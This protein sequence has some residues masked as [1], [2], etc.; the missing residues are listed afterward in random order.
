METE[1]DN[2]DTVLELGSILDLEG[3]EEFSGLDNDALDFSQLEDF[4]AN[5]TDANGSYFA[6]TLANSEASKHATA[7]PTSQASRDRILVITTTNDPAIYVGG[8]PAPPSANSRPTAYPAGSLPHNLPDSPP[9]SGSE[10]PYSPTDPGSRSP[11]HKGNVNGRRNLHDLLVHPIYTTPQQHGGTTAATILPL[12]QHDLQALESPLPHIAPIHVPPLIPISPT[13]AGTS[14]DSPAGNPTLTTLEGSHS[15]V[16]G[17]SSSPGGPSQSVAVQ[18]EALVSYYTQLTPIHSTPSASTETASVTA[19]ASS[20]RGGRKRKS[21][22][23]GAASNGKMV[24]VKQEPGFSAEMS[25]SDSNCSN[26]NSSNG[27]CGNGANMDD[28]Y[29]FDFSGDPSMFLDSNYQCIK[30]QAFQENTWHTLT[31]EAFKELTMPYYKVDADKGFNFSNSDDAF[32]CQK[33]NHFQIT[34]HARVQGEPKYVKA[35]DGYKP[36]ENF[37]VHFYGVKVESPN[38]VIKIEQSQSDRSKKPFHPVLMELTGEQ[39]SKITVG[40]LHFNETT[41]NNMRKKGKPNPDQR[42]F[43]LVVSFNAHST[44][45]GIYPIVAHSSQRIIVRVSCRLASNP[46][47]F[48]SDME[49][50]WQKGHTSD[51]IYHAGRVGINTD[52]PEEALVVYGNC[53]VTGQITHPSDSRAKRDIT[54]LDTKEQLRNVQQL[55]VVR[56]KYNP[57]FAKMLGLAEDEALDTGVIAQE[58]RE[59]IP[60][61]VKETGNVELANGQ[62]IDNFLVV[63]KERIFMENIGAVKELCKVTGKLE[64]RIDQLEKITQFQRGDAHSSSNND[65]LRKRSVRSDSRMRGVSELLCSNRCVQ[66]LIV[67]LV[68]IMAFCLV[69]MATLYILEYHKRSSF[70]YYHN[71]RH[72]FNNS[73]AYVNHPGS[74]YLNDVF[75]NESLRPDHASLNHYHASSSHPYTQSTKPSKVPAKMTTPS[76]VKNALYSQP[77]PVV[78]PP[79]LGRPEHC[80]A[81]VAY[82]NSPCKPYCCPGTNLEEVPQDYFEIERRNHVSL[83]GAFTSQQRSPINSATKSN[84]SSNSTVDTVSASPTNNA[85]SK[86]GLEFKK[87][88]RRQI[89]RDTTKLITVPSIRIV[90]ESINQSLDFSYCMVNSKGY[91]DCVSTEN[92]YFSGVNLTYHVPLSKYWDELNLSVVFNFSSKFEISKPQVCNEFYSQPDCRMSNVVA[93]NESDHTSPKS[94]MDTYV[95]ETAG[96]NVFSITLH[97]GTSPYSRFNVRFSPNLEDYENICLLNDTISKFFE[98]N[99]H[100]YRVCDE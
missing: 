11:N 54:E 28:D 73:H 82:S 29:G 69:A 79:V 26:N 64:T 67:V 87:R 23:S 80:P 31:D 70:E 38:Q 43:Y 91:H 90:S 39:V 3:R 56:Y 60:E 93:N 53:K 33:K 58:V 83:T 40:R 19:A 18:G 66:M 22:G 5:E 9:D 55:R 13:A 4:I 27:N 89:N 77:Q 76:I 72:L 46:G 59:I 57:E 37:Y 86:N 45:G 24:H 78:K 20:S 36:I 12:I 92:R 47:Q 63:N 71:T 84:T 52:R 99:F 7:Q 88:R 61:A 30:F 85:V 62:K 14:V 75:P 100:F 49:L 68:L 98:F 16:A 50:S 94:S 65:S 34:C 6:D 10:P 41:S 8:K 35:T 74:P 96:N 44:D 25:P 2:E 21:S 51:S 15:H 1:S 48:E 17:E 42:Y 32:V 95:I 81:T 97:V